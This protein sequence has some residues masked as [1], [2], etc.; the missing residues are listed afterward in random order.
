MGCVKLLKGLD[1]ACKDLV[2]KYYQNVILMNRNDVDQLSITTNDS[3]HRISFNLLPNKTGYLFRVNENSSLLSASFSKS[4]Q[5]GIPLYNHAVNVVVS[6]VGESIKTL[7]KQLDNSD[8]F[9]A[10]QFKT[11]EVEIYGFD[12]GLRTQDY[13]YEAQ[14]ELGGTVITLA[15]KFDEY[16]PPYLYQSPRINDDFNNLFAGVPDFLSGDFNDDF[17]DDFYIE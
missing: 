14:S 8:Y 16:E 15:S 5:K 10:I 13:D 9:A 17:S 4:E 2:K 7:I 6:G 12:N 1:L 3:Q 11:G